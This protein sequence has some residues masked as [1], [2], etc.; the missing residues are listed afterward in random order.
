MSDIKL[1]ARLTDMLT[2][3]GATALLT[4]IN[5]TRTISTG[6]RPV[7]GWFIDWKTG[8]VFTSGQFQLATDAEGLPEIIS[9][10][11]SATIPVHM[12]LAQ[13]SRKHQDLR[14]HEGEVWSVEDLARQPPD[15]P[16]ARIRQPGYL[17]PGLGPHARRVSGAVSRVRSGTEP[18]LRMS[19]GTRAPSRPAHIGRDAAP[20]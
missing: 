3:T 5:A 20:T 9:V 16:T 1:T 15:V 7:N 19:R 17:Q 13:Q 11:V 18:L 8:N 6:G 10:C 4:I 12:I 14:L 2:D